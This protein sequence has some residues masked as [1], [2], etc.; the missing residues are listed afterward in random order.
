VLLS[1]EISPSPNDVV[2][3]QSER[4][5][6]GTMLRGSVRKVLEAWLADVHR[7][8]PEEDTSENDYETKHAVT[9]H[10][11]K[12]HNIGRSW[13]WECDGIAMGDGCKRRGQYNKCLRYRCDD[14]CDFDLCSS[15]MREYCLVAPPL[16]LS[17]LALV[18]ADLHAHLL[19]VHRNTPARAFDGDAVERV[20]ASFFFLSTRYTWNSGDLNVPESEIFE[21]LHGLRRRAIDWLDDAAAKARGT[22]VHTLDVVYESAMGDKPPDRST[23]AW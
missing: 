5:A 12:L 18:E 14:G 6:L 17:E 10:E 3:A 20:L 2:C 23:A 4:D 9:C 22:F 21:V 8:K 11:H 1:V 13:S 7:R 16:T 19:L 15:C